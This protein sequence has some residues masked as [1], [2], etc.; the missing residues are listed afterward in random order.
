M[1]EAI[2]SFLELPISVRCTIF[3]FIVLVLYW[4][5]GRL[6]LKVLSLIPWAL[7]KFAHVLYYLIEMPISALHNSMGGVFGSID[8]GW[9]NSM[10]RFCS[11]TESLRSK[12]RNPKEMYNGRV[13]LVFLAISAYLLI[14]MYFELNEHIFTF[15][16]EP[17]IAREASVID[18]ILR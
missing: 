3:L 4:I 17:Y 8:Q 2:Y 1:Y 12:M 16:Q 15:W 14:P 9:A 18:F 6:M 5:F 13:F 10:N 11:Y 7:N